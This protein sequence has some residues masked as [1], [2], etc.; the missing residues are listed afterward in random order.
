M[1][2][3]LREA[4]FKPRVK[5]SPGRHELRHPLRRNY[6]AVCRQILSGRQSDANIAVRLR[7]AET[8]HFKSLLLH[9]YSGTAIR[10]YLRTPFEDVHLPTDSTE[11]YPRSQAREGAANDCSAL[12]SILSVKLC[13][14]RSRICQ[15][16]PESA[17][18]SP[19][20]AFLSGLHWQRLSLET[21]SEGLRERRQ[22]RP[23]APLFSLH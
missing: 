6:R 18:S 2:V 8:Q 17:V 12:H 15:S 13:R 4:L 11:Q 5:E 10:E 1:I 14:R 3:L 20:A 23:R 9:H 16:F 7:P 19:Q 21:R 22:T